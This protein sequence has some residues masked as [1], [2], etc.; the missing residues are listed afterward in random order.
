MNSSIRS[1]PSAELIKDIVFF[2]KNGK[3]PGLDGKTVVFYKT[4]WPYIAPKIIHVVQYFFET[5]HML[6]ALNHAFISFI[7]KNKKGHKG[8]HFRSISLCNLFHKIITKSWLLD[9]NPLLKISFVLPRQ[10]LSLIGVWWQYDY[11]AG[12]HA[13][14]E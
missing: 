2:I 13:W 6:K 7:P 8:E 5:R 11:F 3:S 1:I 14:S 9:W 12:N 10:L 4:Y